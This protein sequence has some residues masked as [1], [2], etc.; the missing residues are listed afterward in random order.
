MISFFALTIAG[1]D[2]VTEPYILHRARPFVFSRSL[3]FPRCSSVHLCGESSWFSRSRAMSA[4]SFRPH[5]LFFNFRCKQSTSP[6]R[7]LR[8]PCVTLGRPL[9]HAW[10]TQG[11]PNPKPNQAEGRKPKMQKPDL[12]PGKEQKL[13]TRTCGPQPPSA[14]SSFQIFL[15][16][17]EPALSLS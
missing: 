17:T 14:V 3:A 15:C 13:K 1:A 12:Q 6:I 2:D 5:P 11:P 7:P 9:G 10:A 8:D 4:I 16:G